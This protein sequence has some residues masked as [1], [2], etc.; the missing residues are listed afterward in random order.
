[1]SGVEVMRI[2][3][4][5]NI[6]IPSS[7]TISPSVEKDKNQFAYQEK[8]AGYLVGLGFNEIFTNSITNSAYFSGKELE[9]S[10]KMINNLSA[11]LNIMRPSLLETGLETIAYNINRKNNNLRF[12]EFG[13]TYSTSGIGKYYEKNHL[14][15]YVTG[16]LSEDSWKNKALGTDFYYLKGVCTRILE[17]MDI[18]PVF[19]NME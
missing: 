5:D 10:V 19:F 3:G 17:L 6:D 13:K 8:I 1:Q 11:E 4:Y 14:C 7:I 16:N 2:Y 9:S 18:A 15:L 12:F